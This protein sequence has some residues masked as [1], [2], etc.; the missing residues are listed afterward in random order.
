[1]SL[2]YVLQTNSVR[3]NLDSELRTYAAEIAQTGEGGTWPSPLP[4]STLDP[5]AEAQV[6][7]ADGTVLASTRTLAGLPAVYAL[8][9]ASN[10][11]VRQPAANSTIPASAIVVGT[12]ANVGGA[13]VSIITGTDTGLLDAMTSEFGRHVLIGLP[14]ILVLSMVAVWLIVGRALRP[15]DVIRRSVDDITSE[16]LSRRV[17][18]PR[19]RD[20]IGQLAATMNEMLARLERST[21]R[22]RRFVADASHELRSPLAA[23]RTTLEVGLAHPDIAPWPIIA[24]RAAE[25][26]ERLETLIQQLLLLA[27][28]DEGKL[29]DGSR[30]IDIGKLLNR[31]LASS[32]TGPISVHTDLAEEL[33]VQGNPQHLERMFRNII[34]NAI[35][36]TTT[37]VTITAQHGVGSIV[38]EIADDGPGIASPDHG[39]VFERFVRLDTS[40]D[41]SSGNS[42]LGLAIAADITRAHGGS[43]SVLD[44]PVHGALFVV[45]L[46]VRRTPTT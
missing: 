16:D 42:G 22:Q 20:E 3:Q 7:A 24:A 28:S 41:R 46:P 11:P 32:D 31:V 44:A 40:R 9:I 19:I 17:P 18:E 39:R 27:K 10:Q 13:S 6:I 34:E 21:S 37:A 35:R 45:V 36:H 8:P 38:V 43:I 14:I 5:A 4:Q 12:H 26:S 23:I 25:Q 33:T 2:L 30:E 15:V 1:M 29:T